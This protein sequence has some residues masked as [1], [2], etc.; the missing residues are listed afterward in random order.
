M[1]VGEFILGY[2]Y[3]EFVSILNIDRQVAGIS[4]AGVTWWDPDEP[5]I[6]ATNFNGTA[7]T[8]IDI[9]DA[10]PP[11]SAAGILLTVKPTGGSLPPVKCAVRSSEDELLIDSF[12]SQINPY[13]LRLK[14]SETSIE[15]MLVEEDR[16]VELLAR[17]YLEFR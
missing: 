6:A 11:A 14:D 17:G 9:S 4:S 2:F 16:L 15:A 7:W 3:P 8:R 10:V 13:L 1:R 12:Q 5:P